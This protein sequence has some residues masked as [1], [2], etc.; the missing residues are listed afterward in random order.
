MGETLWVHFCRLLLGAFWESVEQPIHAQ[1]RKGCQKQGIA[2]LGGMRKW[3]V[4]IVRLG[5]GAG[6]HG[7]NDAH[8]ARCMHAKV[9]LLLNFK[10]FMSL[11]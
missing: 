10:L 11:R 3:V 4:D 5:G 7:R 9:Y 2:P 1:K 8:D 6:A